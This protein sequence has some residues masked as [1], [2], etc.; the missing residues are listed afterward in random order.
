MGIVKHIGFIVAPGCRAAD[1]VSIQAILG[2]N[3]LTHCCH[4]VGSSIHPTSVHPGTTL[5]PTTTFADCPPLDVLVVGELD[6]HAMALDD[7]SM[8]TFLSSAATRASHVI[9]ISTGVVALA[10]SGVLDGRTASAGRRH[11]ARLAEYGANA[12]AAE[13]VVRD[14]RFYT[15]G[16]STGAIE[17]AYTVLRELTGTFF[18]KLT[19]L[20]LEYEPTRR[21][22]D[23][24]PAEPVSPPANCDRML[25]V[26]VVSPPGLYLP[27]VIGA[28]DVLGALPNTRV[29]WVGRSTDPVKGI[30]G[31]T[32]VPSTTFANCPPADVVVVGANLPGIHSDAEVLDFLRRQGNQARAVIGVCAGSLL[33]GATGLL[34]GEVATSNFHMTG[35]LPT[36]EIRPA[37]TEVSASGRFY[38]A[39]PA[40]GSFEAAL[41]AVADLHG[42]EVA[43]WVQ[44]EVLEYSPNP[45][46]GVGTP[47][48]AGPFLTA[49]SRASLAP[50]LPL[51]WWTTRAGYRSRPPVPQLSDKKGR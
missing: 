21:F 22:A 18:A 47:A 42:P 33:L 6:E 9:G 25:E 44:H 8:L 7:P 48:L 29:H 26:A 36:C 19:E 11:T 3:F 50:A 20:S 10:K 23:V 51:Y 38:T 5:V 16:P 43:A 34:E 35:L 24:T 15:A 14:G 31:P 32:V 30:F 2:I 45:V 39:G 4:Y 12:V 40:I 13:T 46:F 37:H 17:A 1:V 41:L 49:I 27:D 28:V